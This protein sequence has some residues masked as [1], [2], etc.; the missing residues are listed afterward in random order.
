M[1]IVRE[2]NLVICSFYGCAHTKPEGVPG[3]LLESV[4]ESSGVSGYVGNTRK[5]IS[6]PCNSKDTVKRI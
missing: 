5:A 2:E 6:F 1:K 3:R 4:S